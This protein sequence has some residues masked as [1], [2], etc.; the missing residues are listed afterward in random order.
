MQP[1]SRYVRQLEGENATYRVSLHIKLM[2]YLRKTAGVKKKDGSK[3]DPPLHRE[4]RE[5]KAK[6]E[7]KRKRMRERNEERNRGKE[8]RD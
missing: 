8:T 6:H 1:A 4:I 3:M 5:M 7:R 2:Q